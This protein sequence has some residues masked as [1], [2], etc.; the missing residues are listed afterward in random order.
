MAS[1]PQSAFVEV[2]PGVFTRPSVRFTAPR[3]AV[4]LPPSAPA[5]DS[6]PA[7]AVPL[8]SA[9]ATS[10]TADRSGPVR[11]GPPG[12]DDVPAPCGTDAPVA[13]ETPVERPEPVFACD[14]RGRAGAAAQAERDLTHNT[15]LDGVRAGLVEDAKAWARRVRQLCE[16][17]R[18]SGASAMAGV[19]QFP[20]LE[21]AGSWHVSQLTAARW[22]A[23]AH[24]LELCLPL[25]LAA[26]EAGVLLA[27]Q[28][29]VLL[30]RTRNCPETVA[31]AVEAEVL[32]G[33][34]ALTPSDLRKR[35]DRAVLRV[36]SEQV[37]AEAAEQ[38][39]A[40]AA[41][42]RHVF[43]R[44]E[45]D[46]M[47]VAG[48]VLTAE[49]ML[50]WE[51]GLD[52]LEQRERVADRDAG[53]DRTAAQ[54]RADLFA[55]LPALVLAGTAQDR[56]ANGAAG[57]ATGSP[58]PCGRTAESGCCLPALISFPG[59]VAS[60]LAPGAAEAGPAAPV[61]P[62]GP[63]TPL[64]PWTL[65]PA[66]VA[67]QVVLNV[68]VPVATVLDLSREPGGLARYGPLSA[69]HIRLVRP[70][71]FRKVLVD[72]VSG[73][74]LDVDDRVTP[75]A[76]DAAG[77][78]QQLQQM[79][80]PAV[81]VNADEPQHDPSARLARLVDVRDLHCCG[82]GCSSSRTDRD[83]LQASPQ[84]PTS[85]RNLGRLS[86]RCHRAKHHGWGLDRHDDG[87]VSWRSPLDRSYHRPGPHAP[88]PK[89]DLWQ[90][91]P[92]LRTAP[93]VEV[94]WATGKDAPEP[95][96]PAG[97]VNDQDGSLGIDDEPPF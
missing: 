54:R 76:L 61:L 85:E 41:A 66:E 28:A 68:L 18:L 38:R 81:V 32:P 53:I 42:D 92:P 86:R 6:A 93:V 77:R 91:P 35:V 45:V 39:H 13:D 40:A 74:P 65:G 51:G 24:R 37:T 49:Q 10:A 30:H 62:T 84:G 70:H 17:D 64:L 14:A 73:K 57:S 88:P 4:Q 46:G 95:G 75:A 15:L 19:P 33:A 82:P 8:T 1:S 48:A 22:A 58:C 20:E 23:D 80:I 59:T 87:S 52:L 29:Q 44:P 71:A 47:A 90:D 21:A 25:T 94:Q 96:P 78:R 79:L 31:R 2:L 3:T 97:P 43:T 5:L 60:S 11:E 34:P 36:E 56:A 26:L 55:A 9:G 72:S 67:A 16:I 69:E 12:R 83:H 89:V 63:R 7:S 27:H 50:A